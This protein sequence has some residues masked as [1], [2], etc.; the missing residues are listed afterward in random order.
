[1]QFEPK[2][3][4]E[5][6]ELG[7]WPAGEYN[8]TIAKAEEWIS[9]SSGKESIKLTM[10]VVSSD[11]KS[12]VVFDY[13]TPKFASKWKHCAKVCGLMAKYDTGSIDAADFEGK[14]GVL[15]LDI[16]EGTPQF[17]NSK[18]SVVD[19]IGGA[20]DAPKLTLAQEAHTQA[21]ANAYVSDDIE[22]D[23]EIPF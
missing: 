23:D 15:K 5:I 6:S 11:A 21:K 17:P 14:S 8:F 13:I 16:Q 18:N 3:D 9:Q 10:N 4:K 19:Y 2:T 20:A 1:M 12:R 7:L 22:L